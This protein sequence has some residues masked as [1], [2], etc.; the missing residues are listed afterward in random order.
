MYTGFLASRLTFTLLGSI[1]YFYDEKLD[2]RKIGQS[3]IS[4]EILKYE[5]QSA[6]PEKVAVPY[7]EFD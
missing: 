2:N 1:F 4:L 5:S 6:I 7:R 3:G